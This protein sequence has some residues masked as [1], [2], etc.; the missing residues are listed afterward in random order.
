MVSNRPAGLRMVPTEVF[1]RPGTACRAGMAAAVVAAALLL[2]ACAG[3][4]HAGTPGSAPTST[5]P[6]TP[7]AAPGSTATAAVDVVIRIIPDRTRVRAGADIAATVE[8]TNRTGHELALAGALCKGRFPVGIENARIPFDP[9]IAAIACAPWSLPPSGLTFRATISTSY[10]VCIAP[11]SE[12]IG[13]KPPPCPKDGSMP[14][15]PPGTY[16]TAAAVSSQTTRVSVI[17]PITVT[18]TP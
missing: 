9:P 1:M 11:G 8:V 18:L 14:P 2:A 7:S 13:P 16:R 10:G 12:S 4:P 5:P 6:Q 15:L 17:D 3:A